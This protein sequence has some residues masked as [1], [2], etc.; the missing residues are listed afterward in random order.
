MPYQTAVEAKAEMKT[1]DIARNASLHAADFLH[2]DRTER[3][4][5]KIE[6][7]IPRAL[8]NPLSEIQRRVVD[9]FLH[10]EEGPGLAHAGQCDQLLAMDAVEISMSPTR[11]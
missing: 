10:D 3:E 7:V 1:S 5:E 6:R 8:Q 11:I 4:R 9:D 2:G